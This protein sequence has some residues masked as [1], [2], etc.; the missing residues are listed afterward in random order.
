VLDGAVAEAGLVSSV[1]STLP[2]HLWACGQGEAGR[3]PA[4]DDAG[5]WGRGALLGRPE[6]AGWG[7]LGIGWSEGGRVQ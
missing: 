5:G 3:A 1:L 7:S 4:R 6:E 2:R